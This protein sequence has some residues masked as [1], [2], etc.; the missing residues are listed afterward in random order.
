MSIGYAVR[1][2]LRT[3]L[4]QGGRALPLETLGFRRMGF[5]PILSLLTPAFSLLSAPAVLP[6]NLQRPEYAPLPIRHKV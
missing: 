2:D 1:P 5:S 6:V 3:R 4:T